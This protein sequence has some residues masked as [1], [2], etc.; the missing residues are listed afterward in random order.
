MKRPLRL[1]L[2]ALVTIIVVAMAAGSVFLATFDPNSLKPRIIEAVK[3]ATGR[4]LT[5]SGK[6]GLKFSL[7]PTI[8][9]R[10]VAFANPIGFSRP[11][12]VT[13]QRLELQL[14][15]LALLSSRVEIKSLILVRPDILLEIGANGQPNWQMMPQVS[16]TAPASAQPRV[17]STKTA[18]SINT[19]RIQ[20]GTVAYRDDRTN[21]IKT[22]LLPRLEANS[23]GPDAPLHVD[24][25]VSYDGTAFH[26]LAD[27]GGLSRLQDAAATT[28]WPVKLG[29]TAA[30]VKLAAAGSFTQ[31]LL[32]KGYALAVNGSLP[33]LSVLAPLLP[34]IGVPPLHD[35]TF[36][37]QLADQGGA[38]PMVSALTLHVGG[39]N[40]NAQI[41]GLALTKLDVVATALDQP[42]KAD[43]VARLGDAPLTMTGTF[44]PPSLL[45]PG[46]KP[47]LFSID[48]TVQAP[49]GTATAKGSLAD[50][51]AMSG[52]NID[53]SAQISDLSALS[54]LARM[55]LPPFKAIALHANLT[56]AAGGLRN[57][58]ALH[59]VGLTGPEGDLAGD[60]TVSL[61]PR[62]LLVATLTST[63][64]DL[65]ALQAV[66]DQTPAAPSSSPS[67]ATQQPAAQPQRQTAGRIFSDQPIPF[68]LLRG[69]DADL[70]LAVGTLRSGGADYRKIDTH[71]VLTNG[72][73]AVDPFAADL[74][75]G[76]LDATLSVDANQPAP[77]VHLFVHAPGLA[78]KSLLVLLHQ[79]SYASGNLEV[80]A[81]LDGTGTN[82]HA[83]ATSLDGSL[84][85]AMAGGT[86]DNRLLGS[87][88]GRVMD[89][90][91]ALNLVG[92]G[93]TS[94]LRCFGL[95]L[96]TQHGVGTLRALALSSS[97]LTLTGTGSVNLGG[98]TLD[99]VLRPEA[100]IGGTQV[101]V[102]IQV[103]GPIRA[104]AVGV[105]RLG[106]AESNVGSV[107]G[108]LLGKGT[109][110]GGLLG[111]DKP[112]GGSRGGDVCPAALIAARGGKSP[113]ASPAAPGRPTE[114]VVPNPSAVLRNLFR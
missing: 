98:E 46:T 93:G 12:M 29:L 90:L 34:G 54:P 109:A 100:R 103:S 79:P 70:R 4:D 110:L 65:D 51:H 59:G 5:L 81:D 61:L 82:P 96:D 33:D 6:I 11:Q 106:A 48:V 57:G 85:L 20:D 84:G 112:L 23:A 30:D 27:A 35:V 43:A 40:L 10:T 52:A 97:L 2:I 36:A 91:N 44:G 24:T 41:P 19:I 56:D 55:P 64:F 13:L 17:S 68:D 74:P 16:P 8:E 62:K 83:I 9:A 113:Q 21:V 89:Q 25:D 32:G 31:P 28:P 71:A 1:V 67:S 18:I 105:D 53:L 87:V 15:L 60:A 92:R 73:L 95:R 50:P 66:I 58:A 88:L 7:Q 69:A 47:Q 111:G 42:I 37:T 22:V 38:Y 75:Q 3:R 101:V 14:G 78:L 45:M 94:E 107:A 49:G 76:H 114:P 39:S 80:Y 77:P 63:H 72:K 108:A 26:L 99:L 102:P 104:P 86:L